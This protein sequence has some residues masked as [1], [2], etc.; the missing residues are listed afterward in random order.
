MPII[1]P[2]QLYS[3]LDVQITAGGLTLT[4]LGEDDFCKV[5][6]VEPERIKMKSG[7]HGELSLSKT[8]NNAGLITVKLMSD[9]PGNRVITLL[10]ITNALFPLWVISKAAPKYTAGSLFAFVM[11]DPEN[12]FGLETG[13][14]EYVFG[15]SN[16]A[17]VFV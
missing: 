17:K 2:P 8:T 6:W 5:E 11:T 14:N 4:G 7:A 13:E 10:S 1:E 12:S 9:S 16:L 15:M 3:A